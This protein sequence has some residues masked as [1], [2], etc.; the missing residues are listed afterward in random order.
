MPPRTQGLKWPGV[1]GTTLRGT[2][3]RDQ[4]SH[5][6]A[7][8]PGKSADRPPPRKPGDLPQP[9]PRSLPGGW[10]AHPNRQGRDA[11]HRSPA[12]T[13][14]LS[15]TRSPN[16]EFPLLTFKLL[17]RGVAGCPRSKGVRP[18]P[19]SRTRGKAFPPADLPP[20][21]RCPRHGGNRATAFPNL[22]IGERPNG[23]SRIAGERA[24]PTRM[25]RGREAVPSCLLC[26]SRKRRENS[27]RVI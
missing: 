6:A 4:R 7:M 1:R 17:K 12:G 2:R 22:A 19:K 23:G 27:K 26:L 24:S 25:T 5:A 18:G 3:N 8:C 21:L 14:P 11:L 20:A 15:A 16:S 9:A 10:K 13:P